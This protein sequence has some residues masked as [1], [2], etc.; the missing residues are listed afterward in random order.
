MCVSVSR[1]G[2][3]T[4]PDTHTHTHTSTMPSFGMAR[5]PSALAVEI[6]G[7]S[8]R[9]QIRSFSQ[10]VATESARNAQLRP[11]SSLSHACMHATLMIAMVSGDSTT[12]IV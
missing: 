6:D 4:L 2:Q 5:R 11:T 3:R 9:H 10:S 12:G 7:Q 1:D 8:V